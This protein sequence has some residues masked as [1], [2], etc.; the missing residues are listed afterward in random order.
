MGRPST[1][2]EFKDYCFR[3]LG[4]PVLQVNVE[5]EQAED[6]IDEALYLY[7]E[8]HMDAVQK[9][10]LKLP[11]TSSNLVFSPAIS[12]TFANGEPIV[13][14]TSNA[15]GFAVTQANANTLQM[16]ARTGTFVVGETVTGQQSGASGTVNAIALG[17]MDLH[18]FAIPDGIISVTRMFPPFDSRMSADILFDPQSQ[19]NMSLISNMVNG[20]MTPYVMARQYQQLLNDTLRGRPMIRFQ[21]HQNRLYVDHGFVNTF[22]PNQYIIVECFRV[23]DPEEYA[24]VWSDRWL[25]RYTIALLKRQWGINLSKYNGIQLPGGATLDGRSMLS[26]ANQEVKDLEEE[27]RS[28][29]QLPIDFTIG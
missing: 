4:A 13:G 18:Y 11:I 3:A 25:Q 6:R 8:Q 14:A 7:Q 9:D 1:R 23:L 27:L 17:S 22:R 26:E 29:Y 15:Q 5:D 28:T 10:F 24:D 20:E 16:Y 19:F 21:R 12:G 2:E